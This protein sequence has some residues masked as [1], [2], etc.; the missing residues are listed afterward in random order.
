[1]SVVFIVISCGG[2]DDDDDDDSENPFDDFEDEDDSDEYIVDP[3]SNTPPPWSEWVLTPWV[4]E[5]ES[6]QDSALELVEDYLFYDIP[7]GAIIIDSPWETGYNTFEFDTSIF[8]E[9]QEM[10]DTFHEQGVRVFMWI[11]PNVNTDSPNFQEGLDAGYYVNNGETFEWWKGDGAF[12]DYNNPDALEW[13]HGLMDKMLD[14]DIDGWK[15]DGSAFMLWLGGFV[16][17]HTGVINAH[18]YQ[19]LYYSDF[20]HYTRERLGNDRFITARP[21]DSYGVPIWGPTFA[22]RDVN[23]AGWVGDQDPTWGGMTAALINMFLS[24][25]Q[26]YVNFGSDIA[27]Y[28]GDDIRE[29]NLFI[30]WAQLGALCPIMENGGSGEHRPWMYDEETLNIYRKFADFHVALIPYLYSQGARSYTAGI[31]LMRPTEA[32][33]NYHLGDNIY[34]SAI[35]TDSTTRPI[36]FPHGT[37]IDFWTEEEYTGDSLQNID[38]PLDRYPVFIKKGSIL[39]LALREGTVFPLINEEYPAIT[40]YLYALSGTYAQFDIYEEN[41]V[42]ARISALF[43]EIGTKISLS[44]T[45]REYAFRL[46]KVRMPNTVDLGEDAVLQKFKTIDELRLSESGWFYD[47][48][49]EDLWIKPGDS[50]KGLVITIQ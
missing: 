6:T 18:D 31:P 43:K 2:D 24:A 15:T 30:R 32:G 13:W 9:P 41:G 42:G 33:F 44:A 1:M 3:V 46:I 47:T 14:M 19:R 49:T 7:T 17:T 11:T 21:V 4:W 48:E 22:P 5:D 34:V 25:E 23:F 27:G 40:A 45:E 50:S 39:P 37:W 28:R 26:G 16:Q 20:Y 35:N 29:K 12:I 8:P 36:L 10:I 38:F